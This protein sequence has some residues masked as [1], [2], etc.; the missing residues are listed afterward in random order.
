MSFIT[1]FGLRAALSPVVFFIVAS[2]AVLYIV[3]VGQYRTVWFSKSEPVS[4]GKKAAML[5]G[6]AVYYLAQGGPLELAGHLIFSAHMLLMAL[7]YL[8]AVPLVLYGIPDWMYRAALRN[9]AVKSVFRRMTNPILTLL[10]FNILFSIYHM[11]VVHDYVMVHFTVHRLYYAILFITSFMM[12]WNIINPL[13]EYERLS[14]VKKMG[15]VF[16]N[17]ALLTPSCALIIFASEPLYATYTDPQVW[18]V[19]LGYCVP[20]GA[21]AILAQFSGPEAFALMP[22]IEDQQFGG[23]IMKFVQEIMYIAFL[24]YIF[25]RWYKR[26][27]PSNTVDPIDPAALIK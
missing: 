22:A 10:M 13:P 16:A 14:D 24:F 23:I 17:G 2:I 6:L 12:W 11:P 9:D 27:N 7:S 1:Q 19:A 21:E 5:S 3:S 4:A 8:V 18:A 25:L 20:K 15:Y 26:E